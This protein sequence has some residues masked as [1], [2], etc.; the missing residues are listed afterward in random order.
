MNISLTSEL[1][2]LI[3]NKVRSGLY[4]NASE[5]V[6][7]ALRLLAAQDQVREAQLQQLRADIRLGMDQVGRGEGQ[8][9]DPQAIKARARAS[10]PSK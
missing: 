7:E 3:H 10:R 9:L 5:V 8:P 1:E 2:L 4:G 6:R